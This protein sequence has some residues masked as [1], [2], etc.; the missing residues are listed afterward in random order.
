MFPSVTRHGHINVV[1]PR[2]KRE[3]EG[4]RSFTVSGI[5]IWNNLSTE[6]RKKPFLIVSFNKS[7]KKIFLDK[8]TSVDH[9]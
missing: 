6:L 2:Y 3:N 4:G 7:L 8:Y 5:K 1:C 9:F